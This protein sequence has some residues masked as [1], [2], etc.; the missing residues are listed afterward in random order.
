MSHARVLRKASWN[1]VGNI[2]GILC[3]VSESSVCVC[4]CVIGGVGGHLQ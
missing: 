4:V 1:C 2:G 3:D